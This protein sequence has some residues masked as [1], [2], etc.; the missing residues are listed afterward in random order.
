MTLLPPSAESTYKVR[1]QLCQGHPQ[2][3]YYFLV[4]EEAAGVYFGLDERGIQPP[5]AATNLA[6]ISYSIAAVVDMMI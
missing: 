2:I 1:N 5:E 3:E 4:A 6:G